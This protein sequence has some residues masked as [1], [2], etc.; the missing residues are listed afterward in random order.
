[1]L[2][3]T[4][5]IAASLILLCLF[6]YAAPSVFQSSAQLPNV[7]FPAH[8]MAPVTHTVLFCFKPDADP[9]AV[10][11]VRLALPCSSPG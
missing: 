5:H 11:A 1:M 3:R 8:T 9:E 6:I 4:R 7:P 10:K 2:V